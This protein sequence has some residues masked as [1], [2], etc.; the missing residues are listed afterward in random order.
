MD[1]SYDSFGDMR[2]LPHRRYQDFTEIRC[3]VPIQNDPWRLR[4]TAPGL[5]HKPPPR[6]RGAE[7]GVCFLQGQIPP[8]TK[9][10]TKYEKEHPDNIHVG[11]LTL[12]PVSSTIGYTKAA[13][14]P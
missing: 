2:Q 14:C 13:D 12:I 4:A 1:Q 6:S 9:Q 3:R 7:W 11:Q 8:T 5:L 10:V